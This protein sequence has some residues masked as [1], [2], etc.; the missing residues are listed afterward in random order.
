M[1]EE[2]LRIGPA[3]DWLKGKSG[4]VVISGPCSAESREQVLQTARE[5][6]RIPQV[7]LFRAGVWKPRTRP[8]GFE[9]RGEPALEW[10]K[11]ARAET[12]LK[13]AVEVARPQHIEMCLR[14]GVDV[15]W[16]GARTVVNPFS[17]DE[18]AESLK[19]VDIPVMIKNPVNPD[20]ELWV[21]AIERIYRA[22]ISQIAAIHR[23][24]YCASATAYRNN[25]MWE[26][27]IELKRL[28]PGLPV[29]C[30]PS[31]I[32]GN[33]EGLLPV[34]QQALDLMMD[35]LMIETHIHP[36]QALTDARQQILPAALAELIAALKIRESK[37]E[38]PTSLL[39]LRLKI[40][41]TDAELLRILRQRMEIVSELALEKMKINTSIFQLERWRQLTD[42]RLQQAG[43]LG[44][45]R[46]FI[47]KL[48]QIVHR[49]SI[50]LQTDIYTEK[51]D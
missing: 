37:D 24:F 7:A 39:N 26:I 29:I 42:D 46:N 35:G 49:E 10:L 50:R 32:S 8:G 44:L 18:L 31:H 36:A 1:I 47:L 27:P 21:G 5:L 23:G 38:V 34:A 43:K 33:P 6:S 4:L 20:L 17:I 51:N 30:D 22:G 41:A 13:T 3:G 12:G 40:D 19:G 28:L 15:I 2:Q 9:G 11:E 14:H 16:L 45:D 25:P 48:L